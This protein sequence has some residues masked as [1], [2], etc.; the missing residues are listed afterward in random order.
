MALN[1]MLFCY[2]DPSIN[3]EILRI[4]NS[5]IKQIEDDKF[6]R[7]LKIKDILN[8]I[9]YNTQ[10]EINEVFFNQRKSNKKITKRFYD[11]ITHHY[12]TII[13]EVKIIVGKH[14]MKYWFNQC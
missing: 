5:V 1:T 3:M 8:M 9:D 6:T 4:S 11:N 2:T 7:L 14:F 12:K 10:K 13:R